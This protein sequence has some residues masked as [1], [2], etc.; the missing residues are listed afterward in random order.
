MRSAGV[1]VGVGVVLLSRLAAA[2]GTWRTFAHDFQRTARAPGV[3]AMHAPEAAW[4]RHLGGA[5][6]AGHVLVADVDKDG[7]PDVVHASGGRV[8]SS[9]WCMP[10]PM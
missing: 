4:K 7:R 1:A 9:F 5:L 8:V 6:G 2:D 3:G 10:L